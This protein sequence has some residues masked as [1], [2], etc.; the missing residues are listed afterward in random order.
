MQFFPWQPGD[1]QVQET[2]HYIEQQLEHHR[3]QTFKEEY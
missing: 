3:T 2:P 1:L